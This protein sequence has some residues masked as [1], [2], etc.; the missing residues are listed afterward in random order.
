M[1]VGVRVCVFFSFEKIMLFNWY[2]FSD[3][4]RSGVRVHAT[5]YILISK[6]MSPLIFACTTMNSLLELMWWFSVHTDRYFL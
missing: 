2:I 3:I 4:F 5:T 6:K 1:C